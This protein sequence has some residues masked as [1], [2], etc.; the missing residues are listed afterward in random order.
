MEK[1]GVGGDGCEKGGLRW[2]IETYRLPA[3]RRS[4]RLS[5]SLCDLPLR[6]YYEPKHIP[7]NMSMSND[8]TKQ[9]GF[10]CDRI[11]TAFNADDM[12]AH[13]IVE[14][15]RQLSVFANAKKHWR[16]LLIGKPLDVHLYTS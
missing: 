6:S 15:E 7:S 11:E 4:M 12:P 9:K 14:A 3:V 2:L 16:V 1:S 5:R 10:T 13:D 8:D